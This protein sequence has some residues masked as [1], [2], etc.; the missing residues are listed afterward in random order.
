[1]FTVV[2][3]PLSLH[4]AV[5]NCQQPRVLSPHTWR[6]TTVNNQES[7][8]P[9]PG[10]QQLSTTKSPLSPHLAVYNCQQPRVLSPHT[11]LST[12]VNN[13]ESSLP[14]PGCQ[15]LST[16][17]SPLSRHLAVNNCQ[18]PRVLSPHT[19]L[20][21][22]VNIQESSLPTSGC[23]QLSTIKSPLSPH[24]AVN[25]CQQPR[26]L[27]P[28]TWLSITGHFIVL[29]LLVPCCTGVRVRYNIVEPLFLFFLSIVFYRLLPL[30]IFHPPPIFSCPSSRSPPISAV[31]FPFSCVLD[32]F[33]PLLSLLVCL[34]PFLPSGLP[35][36][37]CFSPIF[38]L[39]CIASQ[40]LSL[41][42]S[43]FFCPPSLFLLFAEPSYSHTLAASV[44]VVLSTPLS[45]DH[46]GMLV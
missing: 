23:Q 39:G 6:S 44:V 5:N 26:V 22:T 7:S 24:L 46:T 20:T 38:L 33:P 21:T 43:S 31:A 10:C 17:K 40:T 14:T 12:T 8:L 37:S 30:S 19:W 16:T 15:Q 34:H 42:R 25:N 13:Q 32:V 2:K 4:L 41:G 9:T 36:S 29:F 27:S 35:I 3:S 45:P 18:Q 1:M 28:H 11:W